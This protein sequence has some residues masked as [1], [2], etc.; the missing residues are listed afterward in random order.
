M[1]KPRHYCVVLA[2]TITR[3]F[4]L[5]LSPFGEIA[6]TTLKIKGKKRPTFPFAPVRCGTAHA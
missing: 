3:S 6:R 1:H 2:T 4:L 5:S